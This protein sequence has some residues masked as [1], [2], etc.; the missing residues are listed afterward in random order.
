MFAFADIIATINNG[1]IE[2][3]TVVSVGA[4]EVVYQKGNTQKTIA[5]S[6]VDGVLYDDGRYITP[7]KT[8]IV[9]ESNE[10]TSNDTW[11][12]DD[13]SAGAQ[14]SSSKQRQ[15]RERKERTGNSSEVGQA[16]KDA[17][18]SIKDAFTIMFDEMGK[19]KEKRTS[20]SKNTENY[21]N[22]ESSTASED[23]W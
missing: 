22:Q 7:P 12:I 18:I 10:S 5:S 1:N 11:A 4:N 19:K 15:K 16:F 20:K 21:S 6:E 14:S 17:G 9:I 2:D 23:G 13:E 8:N 3:V